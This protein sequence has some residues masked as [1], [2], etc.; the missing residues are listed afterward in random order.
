MKE[1]LDTS[2]EEVLKHEGGYVNHPEDPGGAT[3]Q[4]ITKKTYERFLERPVS[5]EEIQNIPIQH[6]KEI[7]EKNYW[8]AVKAN[9][10]PSGV[11]FSVFD[12]AVNSGPRRAIQGLQK[13]VGSTA[14]GLIGPNTLKAVASADPISIISEL[15]KER[16]MFYR[17]LTTFK[18]FGK[19]WIRRNNETQNI[20]LAMSNI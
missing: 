18:T 8:N 6:V 10:L 16:E 3:N 13:A 20:S 17:D 19:G 15:H 1:N 2:I 7:Y 9:D 14:D 5:I 4:G 11:D 12:W